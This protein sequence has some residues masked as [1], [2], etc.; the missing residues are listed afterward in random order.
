MKRI[1]FLSIILIFIFSSITL[2]SDLEILSLNSYTDSIGYLHV[3]GEIKNNSSSNYEYVQPITSFK[4]NSGETIDSSSTYTFL[5]TLAPGQT[6]PFKVSIKNKENIKK[7]SVQVQGSKGGS[8]RNISILDSS[9]HVDSIGYRH[10]TGQVKNNENKTIEY[11]QIIATFYN[12]SNEV[13]DAAF[14]YTQLDQLQ[15]NS[16]SPFKISIKDRSVIDSYKL[17][18]Q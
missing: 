1:A 18:V 12:T 13:V 16:T 7:Y 10:I 14:T 17:Q 15:P 5:D 9:S 4:N 6:S 11:V 8:K 2:A 3:V